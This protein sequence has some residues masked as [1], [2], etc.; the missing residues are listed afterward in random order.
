MGLAT[1]PGLGDFGEIAV[2]IY[3]GGEGGLST[4]RRILLHHPRNWNGDI[5]AGP[6][7]AETSLEGL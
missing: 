2:E 7:A 5:E 1:S 4:S 3:A 6:A